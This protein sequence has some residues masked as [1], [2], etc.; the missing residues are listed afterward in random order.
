MSGG[1]SQIIRLKGGRYTPEG[2]PVLSRLDSI[3]RDMKKDIEECYN[4]RS[5]SWRGS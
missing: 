3:C 4:G 2:K 1:Y 5:L